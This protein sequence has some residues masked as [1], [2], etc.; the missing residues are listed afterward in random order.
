MGWTRV[1]GTQARLRR[2]GGDSDGRKKK[3]S[4]VNPDPYESIYSRVHWVRPLWLLPPYDAHRNDSIP[5]ISRE[6]HTR[7]FTKQVSYDLNLEFRSSVTTH[8][9]VT[10]MTT[11]SMSPHVTFT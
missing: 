4:V 1:Q 6:D 8:H 2:G 3:A 9:Q 11:R 7:I 10:M 5:I